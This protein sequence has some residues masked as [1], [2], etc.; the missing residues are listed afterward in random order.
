MGVIKML[1]SKAKFNAWKKTLLKIMSISEISKCNI[2]R[3][4]LE[5]PFFYYTV[6]WRI[7]PVGFSKSKN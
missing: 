5:S 7:A 1:I 4:V 6:V 2:P 3:L